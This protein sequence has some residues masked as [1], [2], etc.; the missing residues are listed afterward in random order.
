MYGL[1]ESVFGVN[2]RWNPCFRCWRRHGFLT[3]P[4]LASQYV[5]TSWE[6]EKLLGNRFSDT[7]WKAWKRT[8]KKRT[9]WH[10]IPKFCGFR[11]SLATSTTHSSLCLYGAKKATHY[12]YNV[13]TVELHAQ[14]T[15]CNECCGEQYIMFARSVG[16]RRGM[17]DSYTPIKFPTTHVQQK[18]PR[19]ANATLLPPPLVL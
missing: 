8:A 11:K 16:K 9:E 18:V 7:D 17:L 14:N 3:Q 13:F 6:L 4:E 2:W 5:S 10:G 15:L 19:M 1:L 12:E